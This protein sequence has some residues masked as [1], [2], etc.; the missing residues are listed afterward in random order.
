[1]MSHAALNG[2]RLISGDHV[3]DRRVSPTWT[4]RAS[5][6]L[7][8]ARPRDGRIETLVTQP[9]EVALLGAS[10]VPSGAKPNDRRLERHLH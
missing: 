4:G 5:S 2:I 6:S 8:S 1:M 10:G 9:I 3:A 7:P